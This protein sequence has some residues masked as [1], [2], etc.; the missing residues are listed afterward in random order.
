[1]TSTST[2]SPIAGT[3]PIPF[4][5]FQSGDGI[6]YKL[7]TGVQTCALPILYPTPC[8]RVATAPGNRGALRFERNRRSLVVAVT[9]PLHSDRSAS[10]ETACSSTGR[11][12]NRYLPL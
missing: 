12:A 8:Q 1:M 5:F 2:F 7:V 3:P 4:F 10:R 11:S 9:W 6:R